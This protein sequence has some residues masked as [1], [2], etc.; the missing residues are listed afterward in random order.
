MSVRFD[1]IVE[2]FYKDAPWGESE[3]YRVVDTPTEKGERFVADLAQGGRFGKVY[4]EKYRVIDPGVWWA[5]AFE[6]AARSR[7]V[8]IGEIGGPLLESG[9]GG[10]SRD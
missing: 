2:S 6:T 5:Q 3:F 7:G 1:V 8:R 10:V 4:I 9:I